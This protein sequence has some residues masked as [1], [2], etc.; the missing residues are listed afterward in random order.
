MEYRPARIAK[1]LHCVLFS[2]FY[3]QYSRNP[4]DIG[5]VNEAARAIA[6][7]IGIK[8]YPFISFTA[9]MK[10]FKVMPSA[11]FTRFLSA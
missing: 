10:A 6:N 8:N 11:V 4:M 3:D 2:K 7:T 5:S 9:L 1:F